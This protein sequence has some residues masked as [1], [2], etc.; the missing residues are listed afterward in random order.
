[1]LEHAATRAVSPACLPVCQASPATVDPAAVHVCRNHHHPEHGLIRLLRLH[2]SSPTFHTPRGFKWSPARSHTFGPLQEMAGVASAPAA[3]AASALHR[4]LQVGRLSLQHRV[5]LAPLT[6]LRAKEPQLAPRP[7]CVEYYRQRASRGGLLITEATCIS[8]EAL[9]YSHAPGIWTGDQVEGWRAVTEAVH[10]KGGLIFCQL[11]HVGRVAHPSFGKHPLRAAWAAT[12]GLGNGCDYQPCVSAGP[13]TMLTRKGKP[14]MGPTYDGFG[15]AEEPRELTTA[16]VGRIVEDYAHAAACAKASG[17]D[18]VELHAAHGYLIDQFL[19]DGV[20]QR[21]DKY[22]GSTRARCQLLKEAM[23]ALVAEWGEERVG[24]RI[25]PHDVGTM[26]FY[27]TDCSNPSEQYTEAIH[28]LGTEYPQLAYLLLTEPRWSGTNDGN[29]D[30]DPGFDMPVING[31]KYRKVLMDAVAAASSRGPHPPALIGA[32]GFTPAAA[33]QAVT[34]GVYDAI[35]FGRWFISNPDLPHRLLTG[36][37]LNVYDRDS[38]YT[39]DEEGYTD[40]PDSTGAVGV[41]GK[42]DTRQQHQIGRSLSAGRTDAR[43]K[44]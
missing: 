17:F 12:H 5:V 28:L 36:E 41:V 27:G 7:M 31:T 24:V 2:T 19:N 18:G 13:R 42:Y 11:W 16:D 1:M 15:P 20:N 32:G 10:R 44:L 26:K 39:Y 4:Q 29:P 21:R 3:T 8:P 33:R 37:P 43:S 23:D 40:Y 14:L 22:G 35:A 9:G 6:R 38:F 25:S 30:T 34:D